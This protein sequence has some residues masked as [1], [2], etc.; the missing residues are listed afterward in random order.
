MRQLLARQDRRLAAPTRNR[1]R[2]RSGEIARLH[3]HADFK[4]SRRF[5]KSLRR[6]DDIGRE[7][8][9]VSSKSS[10]LQQLSYQCVLFL[11]YKVFHFALIL[12]RLTGSRT[13]AGRRSIRILTSIRRTFI[14]R[15]HR[16]QACRGAEEFAMDP[17]LN[18]RP[19]RNSPTSPGASPSFRLTCRQI[20]STTKPGASVTRNEVWRPTRR[21]SVQVPRRR[22]AHLMPSQ[23]RPE[24]GQTSRPDDRRLT[25][26]KAANH[27]RADQSGRNYEVRL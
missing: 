6:A 13:R 19:P 24:P 14:T 12:R 8:D 2:P 21:G 20:F 23:L 27:A 18:T 11:L 16:R 4:T 22:R 5:P 26:D 25:R 1:D 17:I 15:T 7:F 3:F 9:R 10:R